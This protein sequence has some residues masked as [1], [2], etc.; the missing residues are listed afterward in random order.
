MDNDAKNF[1]FAV[2]GVL[3]SAFVVLQDRPNRGTEMRLAQVQG[4]LEEWSEV[5]FPGRKPALRFR[6]VKESPDFR[7]DPSIYQRL[8][9]GTVPPCFKRGSPMVLTVLADELRSP[10]S[11]VTDPGIQMVWV[12][13]I[14]C[15][16]HD[17]Y[18]SS[19]V[20][21]WKRNNERWGFGLLIA[22]VLYLAYAAWRWI[23]AGTNRGPQR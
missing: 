2:L 23:R 7:V 21:S 1:A 4:E 14:N 22:A 11:S 3:L 6:L 5:G 19:Q 8:L 10:R 9:G 17:L 18:D 16:G 15:S 13:E 12:R 20:A